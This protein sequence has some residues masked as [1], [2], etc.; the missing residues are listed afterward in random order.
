MS[1]CASPAKSY[2]LK[3]L[4]FDRIKITVVYVPSEE[5]YP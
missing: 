4:C 3:F 5:Q 2:K 1:H